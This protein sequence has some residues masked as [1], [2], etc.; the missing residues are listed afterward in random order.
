MAYDCPVQKLTGTLTKQHLVNFCSYQNWYDAR[1]SCAGRG[2]RLATIYTF[3]ENK[4][5]GDLAPVSSRKYLSS[6]SQ[7]STPS[8]FSMLTA[9]GNH[10]HFIC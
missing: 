5:V 3:E 4:I 10:V 1:A 9:R 7:G 2:G 6:Q 8:V